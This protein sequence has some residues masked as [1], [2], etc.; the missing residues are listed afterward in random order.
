MKL[1]VWLVL[2]AIVSAVFGVALLSVPGWMGTT[3][4]MDL[5]ESGVLLARLLGAAFVFAAVVSWAAR[6]SPETEPAVR[7]V[8][9]ASFMGDVF[10]FIYSLMATLNGTMNS[11]GWINVGL[12]GLFALVFTFFLV[13]LY[14]SKTRPGYIR[15]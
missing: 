7:G 5:N 8:V 9:V 15:T 2:G 4:G 3:F 12:Y 11:M 10:G 14:I 13:T 1:G 6:N